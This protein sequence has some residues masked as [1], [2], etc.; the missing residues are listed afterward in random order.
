[1]VRLFQLILETLSNDLIKLLI[2]LDEAKMGQGSLKASLIAKAKAIFLSDI[3][4]LT[5]EQTCR[6]A[7]ALTYEYIDADTAIDL[8]N[9]IYPNLLKASIEEMVLFC[10]GFMFS[11]L[12]DKDLYLKLKP[13]ILKHVGEFDIQDLMRLTRAVFYLDCDDDSEIFTIAEQHALGLIKN[14]WQELAVQEYFQ[15]FLTFHIT[16]KGGREFYKLLEYVFLKRLEDFKDETD[17]LKKISS[18]LSTS[19]LTDPNSICEVDEYIP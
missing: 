14:N 13:E 2:I 10:E 18:I 3:S 15:I 6:L 1:M 17:Y 19:G 4:S 11:Y 5:F 12:V 9:H 7:K 8:Q 16:R